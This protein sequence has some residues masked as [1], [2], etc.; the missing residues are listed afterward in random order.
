MEETGT[1]VVLREDTAPVGT[2]ETNGHFSREDTDPRLLGSVRFVRHHP[3]GTV[4]GWGMMSFG[5]I[6]IER[7]HSG[8]ILAAPDLDWGP[9]FMPAEDLGTTRY[10]DLDAMVV[11]EKRPS[12][13]TLDGLTLSGLPVPCQVAIAIPPDLPTVYAW[14]VPGLNLEFEHP[15]TYTVTV[16]APAYRDAVF[17]VTANG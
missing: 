5:A 4:H 9:G 11:R 12:P 10:V 16:R 14:D 17:T 15:G 2:E 1:A 3:D 6:Q 8:G 13:A 7:L